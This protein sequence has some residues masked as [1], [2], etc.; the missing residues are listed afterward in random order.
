[1][2]ARE[3]LRT[4]PMGSTRSFRGALKSLC[5]LRYHA[6]CLV[7]L[8]R[9]HRAGRQTNPDVAYTCMRTAIS[10]VEQCK[11]AGVAV[12][13]SLAAEGAK[14][15]PPDEELQARLDA[16]FSTIC[17]PGDVPPDEIEAAIA[18]GSAK[19]P[20]VE[21]QGASATP[22]SDTDTAS[23][24]P[25]DEAAQAKRGKRG[26]EVTDLAGALLEVLRLR[27]LGAAGLPSS[28]RGTVMRFT[29]KSNHGTEEAGQRRARDLA[30][31]WMRGCEE[32]E[33]PLPTPSYALAVSLTPPESEL[34]VVHLGRLVQH[35]MADLA[36][37]ADAVAAAAA[38]A[39]AAAGAT[40]GQ[41]ATVAVRGVVDALDR[42]GL[43]ALV[44]V[45]RGSDD[46]PESETHDLATTLPLVAA[47]G[48]ASPGQWWEVMSGAFLDAL[49]GGA[50]AGGV[51]DGLSEA[52]LCRGLSHGPGTLA[53]LVGLA[54][55]A[56]E[57]GDQ[58]GSKHGAVLFDDRMRVVAVGFNHTAEGHPRTRAEAA[59]LL[60]RAGA[61]GE[62]VMAATPEQL[63]SLPF[64]GRPS[65][66]ELRAAVEAGVASP[67]ALADRGEEGAAGG[68]DVAAAGAAAAGGGTASAGVSLI[69][70][71]ERMPKLGQMPAA[72]LRGETEL[73]DEAIKR[74]ATG[75]RSRVA[76]AEVHCFQQLTDTATALGLSVS[77]RSRPRAVP[78]RCA[79]SPE[80]HRAGPCL[81]AA[82]LGAHS[83]PP[84]SALAPPSRPRRSWCWSWTAWAWDSM[85]RSLAACVR[86]PWPASAWHVCFTP[87]SGA[88]RSATPATAR[89]S[90]ASHWTFT[91][92]EQRRG[93]GHRTCCRHRQVPTGLLVGTGGAAEWREPGHQCDGWQ[94]PGHF[95][96]SITRALEPSPRVAGLPM[97]PVH[98]R[99]SFADS[100]AP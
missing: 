72:M 39:G 1:M 61:G 41:D 92:P 33:L 27:A 48:S 52:A 7:L 37:R 95:R 16:V 35:R 55:E 82:P 8:A 53:F 23:G 70:T 50:G 45:G 31:W 43:A 94:G 2:S 30:A 38:S 62:Q 71:H 14:A 26:R 58:V 66:G 75:T 99:A 19:R 12:A 34:R 20:R 49:R 79:S 46:D 73:D 15:V 88:S 24:T 51:V 3:L 93:A 68:A 80:P 97:V 83:R 87:R 9:E 47:S 25:T 21:G 81:P 67:L 44:R 78:A 17:D 40:A 85:T 77:P 28:A 6:A 74:A 89:P 13:T 56:A 90:R 42:A 54:A 84:W 22:K 4:F 59:R 57:R 11:W 32:L 5:S 65:L 36:S 29:A 91:A 60:Q 76:H 63:E 64:G 100:L 69:P 18:D 86:E 10:T 98:R 96:A